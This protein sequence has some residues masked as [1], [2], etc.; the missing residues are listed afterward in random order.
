ML[1]RVEDES[2]ALELYVTENTDPARM[3]RFLLRA[4]ELV[5]LEEL[6]VIPVA[7]GGQYRLW[8]LF[9][10]F[11]TRDEAAAAARSLPRRY[12]EAFRATPRSFGELRRQI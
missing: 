6:Y 4:R 11:A 8:V 7:S 10:E 3:E 2:Y 9:G 12:Q 5:P 1:E